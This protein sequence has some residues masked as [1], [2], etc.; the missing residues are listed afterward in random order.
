M[1]NC[2]LGFIINL[3]QFCFDLFYR[4]FMYTSTY[5]LLLCCGVSSL[6][7][8]L[9]TYCPPK[10]VVDV[11][12]HFVVSCSD[13]VKKSFRASH[14]RADRCFWSGLTF[15]VFLYIDPFQPT[16]TPGMPLHTL[17]STHFRILPIPS[18]SSLF[19]KWPLNML[20]NHLV[21]EIVIGLTA[22]LVTQ[23][24]WFVCVGLFVGSLT[25]MTR[26]RM[27]C[28]N[29]PWKVSLFLLQSTTQYHSECC[30]CCL[31]VDGWRA[32][33]MLDNSWKNIPFH[34]THLGA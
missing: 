19:H 7:R 6:S 28:S 13:S 8:C 1:D 2:F 16:R 15:N 12:S 3:S 18:G 34:I 21:M 10:S 23:V 31:W 33:C 32:L 11:D 4:P 26:E 9:S 20:V 14:T 22:F 29:G 30:C 25:E 24:G 27:V 17:I 5:D